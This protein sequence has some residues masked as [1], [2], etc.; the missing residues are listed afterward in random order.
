MRDPLR[1]RR[2]FRHHLRA[3]AP[4]ERGVRAELRSGRPAQDR[5]QRRDGERPDPRRP[6]RRAMGRGAASRRGHRGHRPRLHRRRTGRRLGGAARVPPVRGARLVGAASPLVVTRLQGLRRGGASNGAWHVQLLRRSRQGRR[7]RGGRPPRYLGGL[8]GGHPG[9][10]RARPPGRCARHRGA[11][12]PAGRRRGRARAGRGGHGL[13][14]L[15]HPRRAR[16]PRAVRGARHRQLHADRVPH[17]P[18]VSPH[19]QGIERAD[20]GRGPHARVRG[21]CRGGSSLAVRSPTGSA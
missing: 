14:G 3:P 19:R 2:F 11:R 16:L 1:A 9:L 8:A 6:P 20:G 4:L 5:L 12:A 13:G 10:R 17:V 18:A 15:G 21:R 7:A